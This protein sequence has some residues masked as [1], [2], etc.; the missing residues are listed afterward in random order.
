M[1]ELRGDLPSNVDPNPF[2]LDSSLLSF[3]LVFNQ[4][5]KDNLIFFTYCTIERTN[6]CSGR[7][8]AIAKKSSDQLCT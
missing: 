3:A 5:A 4:L 2:W 6:E 7:K 8:K 1:E